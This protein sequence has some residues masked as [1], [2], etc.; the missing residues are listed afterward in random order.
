MVNR[1]IALLFSTARI[2]LHIYMQAAD[3]HQLG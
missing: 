3:H 1:K 2:L